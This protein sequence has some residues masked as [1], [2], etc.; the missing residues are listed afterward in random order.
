MPVVEVVERIHADIDSVWRLVCDV[1]GYPG[2]ME[3]VQSVTTLVKEGDESTVS[4]E[5]LLKGSTLKWTEREHRHP[6]RY[7]VDFAQLDGDLERFSG[8]WQLAAAGDGV[9]DAA[10]YIDFEIG[11]PM[12]RDMLNPVAVKALRENSTTMLKSL[13]IGRLQVGQASWAESARIA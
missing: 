6:D 1:D 9:T 3:P 5:V 12:L 2:F 11:I 8:Y 10:L 7:R 4:W 13:E